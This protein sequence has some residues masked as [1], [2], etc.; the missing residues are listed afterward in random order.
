[1]NTQFEETISAAFDGEL[2]SAELARDLD[3]L[4]RFES[5]EVMRRQ[6]ALSALLHGRQPSRSLRE[7]LRDQI[8]AEP[9]LQAPAC[10]DAASVP[11]LVPLFQRARAWLRQPRFPETVP[12]WAFAASVAALAV[13]ATFG[14][15]G[16]GQ[17][18][19][20]APESVRAIPAATGPGSDVLPA[21][22]ATSPHAVAVSAG[23]PGSVAAASSVADPGRA[24]RLEQWDQY[25]SRHRQAVGGITE[26][27][28][29][30]PR[31]PATPGF[32][33]P[34]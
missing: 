33:G 34:L 24:E 8:A 25:L 9:P 2:D 1:M 10:A 3:E 21:A 5:C 19:A 12:S 20:P 4:T 26:E 30:K 16:G 28:G 15:F 29:A 6:A 13:V 22:P 7:S 17:G 18:A 27:V 14:G 31:P 32:E 23:A 11:A